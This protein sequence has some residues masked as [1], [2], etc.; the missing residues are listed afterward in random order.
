[1]IGPQPGLISEEDRPPDLGGLGPDGIASYI[2]LTAGVERPPPDLAE[3]IRE[4]TGGNPF[5]IGE[6]V[7]LMAAEGRLGEAEARREVAVP[8][9]VREVV[10][11]RLDRLSEVANDVLRLAAVCGREFDLEVLERISRRQAD[12][13]IAALGEAVEA[14]LV[15]ESGG[16][17]GRR[18]GGGA[19][20]GVA[21]RLNLIGRCSLPAR[22]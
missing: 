8:Q 21:P 17:P 18:V 20:P 16:R 7:R 2:E 13:V 6:V 4:Q 12:E 22:S 3:A 10:G 19:A 14:R 11:R 5:F 15:A 9:G 1:M